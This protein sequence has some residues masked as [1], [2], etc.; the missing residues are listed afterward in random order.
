M[1]ETILDATQ[2]LSKAPPPI[3]SYGNTAFPNTVK[4]NIETHLEGNVNV[5]NNISQKSSPESIIDISLSNGIN[6]TS[7][8][9]N[10]YTPLVTSVTNDNSPLTQ[11]NI[12]KIEAQLLALKSYVDCELSALTFEI[13]G[14]SDSIKNVLSD[15]QNEEHEN[16]QIEILKKN[17]I[18][19]QNEKKSKDTI[20]ESLLETQKTLPTKSP[21]PFSRQ[22]FTANNNRDSISTIIIIIPNTSN[23]IRK[24]KHSNTFN[25]LKKV[26]L[27]LKKYKR[28]HDFRET[29][30]HT[31]INSVHYTLEIY[32]MIFLLMTCMNYLIYV[33][34]SIL[35]KTRTFK[36]RC[37][38]IQKNE[39][40]L[41]T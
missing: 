21:K 39:E 18:L 3:L 7:I 20:I 4:P 27:L 24:A 10:I 34:P 29:I 26:I 2:Q 13:D 14:F 15:L 28:V 25:S 16:S 12:L 35:M 9:S 38:E 32:L 1:V 5:P 40:V 8:P 41:L 6:E 37:L 11:Q 31:K 19:L 30:F 36:C 22:K 17:V 33:V 23:E